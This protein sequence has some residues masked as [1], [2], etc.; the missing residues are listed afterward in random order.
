MAR[1][2]V[3]WRRRRGESDELSVWRNPFEA[4]HRGMDELFEDFLGNF[5]GGRRLP[6]FSGERAGTVSP[7]FEVS[8]TDEAVQVTAE[9]PGLDDKDIEVTLEE[10][11]LAVKGEKKQEREEK[12]K[13]YYFS[14][15]SYGSFQRLIPL[16]AGVEKDKAKASFKKGV[17]K[18]EIPKSPA[19]ISLKNKIA[20]EGGE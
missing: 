8:E 14:E 18:I 10:N 9:L 20:I 7:R 3:P 15:R 13:N 2:L 17:L 6:F 5:G 1:N 4:L 16:P 12:K 19:A 11:H